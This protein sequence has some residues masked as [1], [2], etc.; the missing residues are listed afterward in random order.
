M[1]GD[2][3]LVVEGPPARAVLVFARPAGAQADLQPAYCR[4]ADDQGPDRARAPGADAA[5]RL[6]IFAELAD[7]RRADKDRHGEPVLAETIAGHGPGFR[8]P[9]AH[10]SQIP[11]A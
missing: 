6:V 4:R 7:A 9:R 1:A 5:S 8:V 3:V 10:I 2:G 11:A